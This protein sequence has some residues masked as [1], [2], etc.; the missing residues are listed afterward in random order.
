[1]S[2][3]LKGLYH[4]LKSISDA[5]K[6]CFFKLFYEVGKP[7]VIVA[8]KRYLRFCARYNTTWRNERAVEIP[9]VY[10]IVKQESGDILEVGNVLSHYFHINHDVVDKYEKAEGVTNEDI[11]DYSP[12]KKYDLIIS[13]STL[14]HVGWGYPEPFSADKIL[15]AIRN[16]QRLL[17]DNGKIVVTLPIYENPFLTNMIVTEKIKFKELYPFKNRKTSIVIGTIEK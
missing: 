1:L 15:K 14:E 16:M 5:C 9:V 4:K 10:D 3:K 17:K 12:N 8:G 2:K 11:V 13:I 6:Y 7:A